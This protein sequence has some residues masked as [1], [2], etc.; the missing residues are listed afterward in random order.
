MC[1][2]GDHRQLLL[3]EYKE[4]GVNWRHWGETR[5]KQLTAFLTISSVLG[6]AVFTAP[7]VTDPIRCVLGV[8]GIT[9]AALFWV[10]EER[11][12]Y[13]R[14]AY[15]HRA[16]EIEQEWFRSACGAGAVDEARTPRQYHVTHNPYWPRVKSEHVFRLFYALVAWLWSFHIAAI[17][18][19]GGMVFGSLLPIL[20][21]F[22]SSIVGWWLGARLQRSAVMLKERGLTIPRTSASRIAAQ[23]A[24]SQTES[25]QS[26]PAG[27]DD[28][29]DPRRDALQDATREADEEE[30]QQRHPGKT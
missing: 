30:H 19:R 4:V 12:T 29:V 22:V 27:I 11:A 20:A 18:G 23:D 21:T 28:P 10:L 8:A 13:Y 3:D 9:L 16:L 2:R 24:R 14:R 6:A 1:E 15:L 7:R 17:V 26:A 25:A 5:W